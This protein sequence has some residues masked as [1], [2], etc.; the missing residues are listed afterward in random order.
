MKFS[1]FDRYAWY[2]KGAALLIAFLTYWRYRE[3]DLSAVYAYVAQGDVIHSVLLESITASRSIVWDFFGLL[4]RFITPHSIILLKYAGLILVVLDLYLISVV[5]ELILG[6]KFWGFLGIFLAALS[7]FAVVAAVSG[8]P[9]ASAAALTLLFLIALYR[10]QY[11]YAGVIAG[12]CFAANLPGLI[13]FLIT[14]LD[15]LQN[16][17]DK[18]QMTSRLLTSAA[19]FLAVAAL[20]YLYSIYSGT[21]RVFSIPI[22]AR[23]L[24][25]TFAGTVPLIVANVL[26]VAGIVYLVTRKRWDVYRTHFHTLMVWITSAAMCVAQPTTTNLF[27]GLVVSTILAM[28]FL[29]GFNSLWEINLF[30]ADTFVFVF[31]AMFLLANLYS[32]NIFLQ[33][34][35]LE[36]SFQKNET[37]SDVITAI[38]TKGDGASIVSNFAPAE[39][40]VKLGRQVYQVGH[41][42]LPVGSFMQSSSPVVYVARRDSRLDSL[43]SG[44]KVLLDT[45]LD[46]NNKTSYVQVVQ[47]RKS[48]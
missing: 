10:N 19:A 13:F 9:A 38:A 44:C 2:L 3:L 24:S 15:M 35:A 40:S 41:G 23:D 42:V 33:N 29:Q 37:V 30:S 6:G 12:V 43:M 4:D 1:H 5:I 47:Y 8:G 7:P 20:A 46:E 27:V 34:V 18:K 11:V 28:F 36:D 26:N 16:L 31:V 48:K 32:N 22:S 21:S 17:E 39:L 45:P 25:W 14:I